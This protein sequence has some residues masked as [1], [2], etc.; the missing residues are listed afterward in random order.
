MADQPRLSVVVPHRDQP[1]FLH[2]CLGALADQV[3]PN[4]PVEVIVVDNGSRQPP[5][6]VVERFPFARLE[7]EASPGPGPAR[8]R[9]AMLARSPL[10]GFLDSDCLAQPG[11]IRTVVAFFD[12]DPTTEVIGGDV[13][14]RPADPARRTAVEAF[15][16]IFGYRMQMY[17]ERDGY[18]ATLNMAVRRAT[19]D[20]VGDFA[21]IDMA[22]DVDWGQRASSLGVRIDHV[23][24]MLV[25]TPAR[26][27]FHD[28][29]GK[30]DRHVTHEY[31]RVRTVSDRVRW[32]VR[33]VAVA[34]SPLADL[35]TVL[36]SDRVVGPAERLGAM[37]CLVRIRVHRAR[38][39][40]GLVAR[41]RPDDG[42]AGDWTRNS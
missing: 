28:L 12:A 29:A 5:T 7:H 36:R 6:D 3:T 19:F 35:A 17:V 34:I 38:R 39:M 4:V 10:I 11:W 32:L 23:P 25:L 31:A 37:R 1:R 42:T 22:E 27:S 20:R 9:G 30:W 8:N 2:A 16:S 21:G 18:T 41:G 13:R 33:A 15:E 40:V 26:S 24:D 14:I